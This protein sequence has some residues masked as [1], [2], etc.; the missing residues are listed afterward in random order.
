MGDKSWVLIFCM[1]LMAPLRLELRVWKAGA[2]PRHLK[3]VGEVDSGFLGFE[4][5]G[6]G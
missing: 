2:I 4:I 1:N 3:G 5:G 6:G